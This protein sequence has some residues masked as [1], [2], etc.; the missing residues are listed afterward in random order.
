MRIEGGERRPEQNR[1][2]LWA[3]HEKWMPNWVIHFN[4]VV[5]AFWE[6]K[7]RETSE[8]GKWKLTIESSFRIK[9]FHEI[10]SPEWWEKEQ[11]TKQKEIKETLETLA[12]CSNRPKC[13]NQQ[14]RGRSSRHPLIS[15]NLRSFIKNTSTD[16]KVEV[17]VSRE[18]EF[19]HRLPPHS[20]FSFQGV[21]L[22]HNASARIIRSNQSLVLQKVTR[23]SSGNYAC[24]ALNS[25]GETISN[26]LSL[27]VKCKH[28][29]VLTAPSTRP[30][31]PFI[32]SHYESSAIR[33]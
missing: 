26:Q 24:S 10:P 6:E 14:S 9:E 13:E 21:H 32:L 19:N 18:E 3:D 25:E 1:R 15:L 31:L 20:S 33:K 2:S 17:A 11:N 28:P 23:N 12:K 30:C 27:R 4:W 5:K 8:K 29:F 7:Q 22:T 16:I